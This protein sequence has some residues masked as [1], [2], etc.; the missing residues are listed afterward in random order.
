M[1]AK[2][3]REE[4]VCSRCAYAQ[5]GERRKGKHNVCLCEHGIHVCWLKYFH[6][7]RS[8]GHGEVLRKKK[9]EEGKKDVITQ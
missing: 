4:C 8:L 3:N 9:E 6:E 5:K 1:L 7:L 2:I